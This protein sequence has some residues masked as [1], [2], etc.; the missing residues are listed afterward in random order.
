M[1]LQHFRFDPGSRVRE[2]THP[3]EQIGYVFTGE[4]TLTVAGTEY[5]LGPD[6]IYF[7]ESN[8]PHTGE[9]RGEEPVIGIDVFSP[10]REKPQWAT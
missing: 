9:N 8:E 2:H 7:L 1:S 5:V 6:E 4:L 10:P 3:Q